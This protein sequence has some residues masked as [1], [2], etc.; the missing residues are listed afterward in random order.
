MKAREVT[1]A[2][3]AETSIVDSLRDALKEKFTHVENAKNFMLGLLLDI[4]KAGIKAP[5]EE[6]KQTTKEDSSAQRIAEAEAK[7]GLTGP[8]GAMGVGGA[9]QKQSVRLPA[10]SSSEGTL[11]STNLAELPF[12]EICSR[13]DSILQQLHRDT[14]TVAAALARDRSE[15]HEKQRGVELLGERAARA[16]TA[17]KKTEESERAR[18]EIKSRVECQAFV[19]ESLRDRIKLLERPPNLRS[20]A[21]E[22]A[23]TSHTARMCNRLTECLLCRRCLRVEDGSSSDRQLSASGD[24]RPPTAALHQHTGYVTLTSHGTRAAQ[25]AYD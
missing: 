10:S 21:A 9:Q 4:E 24:S 25:Q 11:N 17:A 18:N 14:S 12:N 8:K 20:F 7:S 5:P 3:E 1:E 23:N 19:V 15:R 13:L 16:E 2:L 6:T 22:E